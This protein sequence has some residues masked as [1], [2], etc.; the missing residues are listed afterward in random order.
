M[1]VYQTKKKHNAK[2]TCKSY[3]KTN[4]KSSKYESSASFYSPA[5]SKLLPHWIPSLPIYMVLLNMSIQ[6]A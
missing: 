5:S 4:K 1:N 3:A 6:Y 2:Q